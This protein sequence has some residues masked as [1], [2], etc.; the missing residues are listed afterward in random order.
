[1]RPDTKFASV[2]ALK[3]QIARDCAKA[4]AILD[5]APTMPIR[6]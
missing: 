3:Q 1:V 4:Q 5:A 6:Q 2:E